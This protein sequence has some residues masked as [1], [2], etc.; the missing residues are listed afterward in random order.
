MSAT[1]AGKAPETFRLAAPGVV[2][3][4][5]PTTFRLDVDD[6][7]TALLDAGLLEAGLRGADQLASLRLD[8]EN[9]PKAPGEPKP[10][11]PAAA[12]GP[13][14]SREVPRLVRNPPRSLAGASSLACMAATLYH[15][16]RGEPVLGQRAVGAVVMRRVEL[17]RNGGTVCGVIAE[18]GQFSYVRGDRSIPPIKERDAW[19]RSVALAKDVLSSPPPAA[20]S[21]ADYYHDRRMRPGWSAKMRLVARIGEHVFYEDPARRR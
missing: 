6:Q 10:A 12:A 2:P 11:P 21:R 16:A 5:A 7:D 17:G 14:V 8:P 19:I 18:R 9:E 1:D 4:P 15:E 13:E 3:G 20:L